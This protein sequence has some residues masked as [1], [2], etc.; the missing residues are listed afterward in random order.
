MDIE[1]ISHEIA[2]IMKWPYD[3]VLAQVA[4]ELRVQ[5]FAPDPRYSTDNGAMVAAAGYHRVRAGE[6]LA[7]S[8]GPRPVYPLGE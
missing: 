4:D 3:D 5:V 7:L 6:R 8:E 2:T 1:V